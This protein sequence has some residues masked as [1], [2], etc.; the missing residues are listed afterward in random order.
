MKKE[1]LELAI[2]PLYSVGEARTKTRG[3][4][5]SSLLMIR[6]KVRQ[7]LHGDKEFKKR[8]T[9]KSISQRESE[10]DGKKGKTESKLK[11]CLDPGLNSS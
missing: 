7:L 3:C 8:C 10:N 9:D 11:V 2:T 5:T 4:T 6:Y 1:I